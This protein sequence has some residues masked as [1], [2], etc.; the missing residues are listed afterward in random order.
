ML[1][2]VA[3]TLPKFRPKVVN[4]LKKQPN[5]LGKS[6]NGGNVAKFCHTAGNNHSMGIVMVSWTSVMQLS[7]QIRHLW[8]QII[9]KLDPFMKHALIM[10]FFR[11]NSLALKPS[12]FDAQSFCAI[13]IA[14]VI[15]NH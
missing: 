10:K 13:T 7:C 8:L 5:S 15:S 6:P 2:K 11:K 9:T 3:Q 1:K 14:M 4:V 12:K